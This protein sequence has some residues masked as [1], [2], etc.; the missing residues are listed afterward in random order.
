MPTPYK[1]H[2]EDAHLD[3]L[4]QK[5]AL[6]RFPDEL[7][8]AQWDYGAPLTDL[9]RLVAYWK[10]GYDW[11]AAERR[12]NDTLPQF[13]QLV[14]VD[15]FGGLEVHFVHQR[16]SVEGAIPLLFVHG[17]KCANSCGACG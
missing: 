3:A 12:L 16:S 14:E 13:T 17:C 6:T 5:L 9:K 11:R 1:I 15:G 2:V 10:D 7:D 8:D 4:R